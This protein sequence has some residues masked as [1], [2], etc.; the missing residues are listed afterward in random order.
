MFLS[1]IIPLKNEAESL[2]S[3]YQ[4]LKPV[5]TGLGGSHEILFVNDGSTD[6]SAAVIKTLAQKDP[7]VKVITLSR[8]FGH[9]AATTAG[10]DHARGDAA[11]LIDA[12]LQDPPEVIPEMVERWKAGSHVVYARRRV[13][14]GE[15]LF[16]RVSAWFFY[17]I[18]NFLSDIHLP[19]DTGDFRLM[20]RSVVEA[21]RGLR[22]QSR[23]VRGL[24]TWVGY[25]QDGIDYER[26]P[27]VSGK[28]EYNPLKLLLL[29]FDAVTG[30]SILP[31]RIVALTG[32]AVTLFSFL[33]VAV[34]VTQK[35]FFGLAVPGYAFLTSGLFFL[36]GTQLLFLGLIGEYVGK[37]YRQVQNR[38]LYIINAEESL[39]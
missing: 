37:I 17:R 2:G 32:L 10:L 12:D 19:V 7:S 35:L 34:V 15:P 20:D 11:V 39:L 27:R 36:G 6:N 13:R 22:E 18:V 30:F 29:A 16:R 38:P 4:R 3:L 8:N 25:T 5:L 33:A 14:E 9:E 1:V 23:Y 24:V 26:E 31:L 28:S 21:V